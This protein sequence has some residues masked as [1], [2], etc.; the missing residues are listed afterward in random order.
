MLR[1]LDLL[2]WSLNS[3]LDYMLFVQDVRLHM[4][5]TMKITVLNDMLL[6]RRATGNEDS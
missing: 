6:M 3:P 4:T 1:T 5:G 2:Q